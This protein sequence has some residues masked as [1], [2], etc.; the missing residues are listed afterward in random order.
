[1]T[2]DSP[3]YLSDLYW[4]WVIRFRVWKRR[5]A[6]RRGKPMVRQEISLDL[7]PDKDL[8]HVLDGVLNYFGFAITVTVLPGTSDLLYEVHSEDERFRHGLD[9]D[10]S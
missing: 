9:E 1:M 7:V 6:I 4:G 3:T 10:E 2:K 8:R 5:R